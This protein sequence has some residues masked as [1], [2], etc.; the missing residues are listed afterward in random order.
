MSTTPP[1]PLLQISVPLALALQPGQ[2]LLRRE[3]QAAEQAAPDPNLGAAGRVR[4]RGRQVPGG[5]ARDRG[6]GIPRP[7]E[8]E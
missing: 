2:D 1:P 3:L 8:E 7:V 4:G 6:G 5:W